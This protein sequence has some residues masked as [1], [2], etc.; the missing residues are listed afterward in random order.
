L[1]IRRSQEAL[2]ATTHDEAIL[3]P[4]YPDATARADK[5]ATF[6]EG[7]DALQREYQ[8]FVESSFRT[9]AVIAEKRTRAD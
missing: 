8:A 3:I 4:S 7:L 5:I 6:R 2:V 1:L 9:L